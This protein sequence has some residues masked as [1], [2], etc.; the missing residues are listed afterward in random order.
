MAN[1]AAAD[2]TKLDT[3]SAFPLADNVEANKAL[4]NQRAPLA[5]SST[6][7]PDFKKMPIT[8]LG[9]QHPE[10]PYITN[11]RNSNYGKSV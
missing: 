4:E 6:T 10:Q 3:R 9:N 5:Y 2:A 7:F 1:K 8:N 11:N